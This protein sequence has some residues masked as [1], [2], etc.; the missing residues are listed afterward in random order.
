M[1]TSPKEQTKQSSEMS[2]KKHR[3][4]RQHHKT[5][6]DAQKNYHQQPARQKE[7]TQRDD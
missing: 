2:K 5:N 7:A 1:Q 3:N 4:I 6:Y